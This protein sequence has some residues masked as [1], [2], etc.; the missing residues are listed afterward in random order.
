MSKARFTAA[1]HA[2]EF[3]AFLDQRQ[4]MLDPSRYSA[5]IAML[6][7]AP[8]ASPTF[9]RWLRGSRVGMYRRC[10]WS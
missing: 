8:V 7:S 5:F 4:F 1:S 2:Q 3:N 6:E 10:W 9:A